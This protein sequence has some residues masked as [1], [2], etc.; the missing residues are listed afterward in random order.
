M[1]NAARSILEFTRGLTLDQFLVDAKTRRAVERELEILGEAGRRISEAFRSQHPE[2][3]WKEVIG[4][5]NVISHDYDKIDYGQVYG[6]VRVRIP[7]LV[8]C[9]SSLVPKPP[10]VR[11]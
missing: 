9:L 7:H 1:L 5:R 10:D 8:A 4:L 3:P 2:I 6:I 11:E